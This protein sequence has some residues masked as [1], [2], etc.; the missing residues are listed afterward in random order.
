MSFREEP[1]NDSMA[2]SALADFCY[3]ACYSSEHSRTQS[4]PLSFV[5]LTAL[6]LM[7]TYT[8]GLLTPPPA[9][10][11]AL[12]V[13]FES[14]IRFHDPILW[15]HVTRGGT[16]SWTLGETQDRL[17]SLFAAPLSRRGHPEV[18][19]TLWSRLAREWDVVDAVFAALA[20]VLQHSD[21][22]RKIGDVRV[23][24]SAVL[25]LVST[26][27]V[28]DILQRA[29]SLKA[30]TPK[31]VLRALQ[32]AICG[33]DGTS[34][35]GAPCLLVGPDDALAASD[36]FN[37]GQLCVSRSHG[38]DVARIPKYSLTY[39]PVYQTPSAIFERVHG[40]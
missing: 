26:G 1:I 7:K 6:K 21:E 29:A 38:G 24:G 11:D 30:F 32:H 15:W 13:L 3:V 27:E 8:P 18:C 22:L 39:V 12:L 19:Q 16:Q 2:A 31:S 10:G 25:S 37:S 17:R 23:N 28:D 4:L 33:Q 35:K 20:W 9:E 36:G 14:L 5:Y 34:Q 40:L